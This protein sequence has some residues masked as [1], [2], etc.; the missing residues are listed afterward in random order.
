MINNGFYR[1]NE[2]KKSVQMTNKKLS[3]YPTSTK[4]SSDMYNTSKDS[5]IYEG[6]WK[7]SFIHEPTSSKYC[8][9][10]L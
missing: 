4:L 3:A 6:A 9:N 1:N 7:K 10:G 2:P 5:K 8:P